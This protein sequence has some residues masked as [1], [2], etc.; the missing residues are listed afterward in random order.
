M[1]HFFRIFIFLT[2]MFTSPFYAYGITFDANGKWETSFEYGAECVKHWQFYDEIGYCQDIENDDK[3]WYAYPSSYNDHDPDRKLT[4]VY[5]DAAHTGNYGARFWAFDGTNKHSPTIRVYMPKP[6]PELWIRYY[7]RFQQGFNWS[8]QHYDKHL[9][10]RTAGPYLIP[11]MSNGTF[12]IHSNGHAAG[13]NLYSS[14]TWNDHMGT[15]DNTS[16]GKWMCWEMYI[17]MDTDGTNGIERLWIDG[18]LVLNR[19]N[20]NH[21]GGNA[22]ARQGWTWFDWHQNHNEIDNTNGPIGADYA[23]VDYD[24]MVIYNQTPPNVDEHGNPF[25]GPLPPATPWGLSIDVQ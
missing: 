20:I 4:G 1:S 24:D 25:I 14:L 19:N 13:R 15:P 16:N 8:L 12:Y 9:Y 10:L 7:I 6:Q 3:W 2:F 17:K 22:D 5:A 11:G 21:S 18:N 23:Y